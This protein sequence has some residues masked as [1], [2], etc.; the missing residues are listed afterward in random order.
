MPTAAPRATRIAMAESE[1]LARVSGTIEAHA[2]RGDVDAKD[3]S[4]ERVNSRRGGRATCD[5]QRELGAYCVTASLVS[6]ASTFVA[7]AGGHV[8]PVTAGLTTSSRFTLDTPL[9]P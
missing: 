8:L 7:S 5:S 6:S 1:K 3:D 2:T 9:A 4:L